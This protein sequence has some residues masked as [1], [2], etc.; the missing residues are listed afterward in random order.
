MMGHVMTRILPKYLTV[1]ENHE[2]AEPLSVEGVYRIL[3]SPSKAYLGDDVVQLESVIDEIVKR[4]NSK[5]ELFQLH[6]QRKGDGKSEMV[7]QNEIY[8][9]TQMSEWFRQVAQD[10]P[11]P[12]DCQWFLCNADSEH[13]VLTGGP[14]NVFARIF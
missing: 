13:F 5:P 4:Y 12:D 6:H 14:D 2:I 1:T 9:Q 7:A 8:C 10:H 11:L 3:L